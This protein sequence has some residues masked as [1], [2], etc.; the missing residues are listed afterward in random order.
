MAA[1]GKPLLPLRVGRVS[2]GIRGAAAQSSHHRFLVG[3]FERLQFEE[4]R[5][6]KHQALNGGI[7]RGP[8]SHE[9]FVADS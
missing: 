8:G 9:D 1:I 7:G 2:S 3:N 4:M 5:P 6:P